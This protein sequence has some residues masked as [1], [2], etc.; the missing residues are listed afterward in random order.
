MRRELIAKLMLGCMAVTMA[1]GVAGVGLANYTESGSFEFYRQAR[2]S[3][4]T[5][6]RSET[7]TAALES[8]DL[9]FASDY[10]DEPSGSA[11]QTSLA[12]FEP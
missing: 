11:P 4:W 10:R 1:G 8:T 2:V 6:P 3:E 5:P 12:S 9:T 7:Q